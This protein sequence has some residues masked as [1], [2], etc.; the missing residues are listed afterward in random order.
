M[1]ADIP[2]NYR[3]RRDLLNGRAV[4]VTGAGSGMGR[5]AAMRYA[6][7]GA[8]VVLSG[9]DVPRLERVYD[10]IER[11][12]APDAFIC[13]LDLAAADD[14]TYRAA[15]DAIRDAFGR[16]DG[17]LHAASALGQ[18]TPLEQ[19]PMDVWRA[20]LQINL[21]GALALTQCLLP[22]L[23]RADD[24]S[25]LFTATDA[26]PHQGAYWGA[27]AVS[28]RAL[29]GLALALASELERTSAVRVN[30]IDPGDTDTPLR[31]AAFPAEAAANRPQPEQRMATYLYLMGPDSR[32]VSGRRFKA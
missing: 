3:A 25:L 22:L 4:L 6:A 24:A 1:A 16:L 9:R 8:Q 26:G 30:C 28:Q 29:E 32:G 18:R 20:T 31:R 21:S 13:P 23:K 12:G 10:E 14:A 17:M 5:A 7:H 2:P 15:H 11:A 27:Y 19:F